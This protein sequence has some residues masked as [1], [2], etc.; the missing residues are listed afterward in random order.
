M[1]ELTFVS[2]NESKW[3]TFE[4]FTKGNLRL[5]PD[6]LAAYYVDIMDDL[7]YAK[8]FYPKSEIVKYLN[9]LTSKAHQRVYITKKEDRNRFSTFFTEEI[10]LAIRQCHKELL[11]ALIIFLISIG[12]G[13]VCSFMNPDYPR[14][15]LGDAYVDM[16]LDNIAKGDPMAVYKSSSQ[17]DMFFGIGSNNIKV[18]MVSFVL[19]LI[20]AIFAG[21]ILFSNGIMVGAFQTFFIQ[22][23]LFWTSF[24]TIFIHGALEL[25]AI[26]IIA[27]AGIV[28]GNSWWFPGTYSRIDSFILAAKKSMKIVLAIL[29][30][31][32]IAALIES[33]VTRHYQSM[34]EWGGMAIIIPSFAYII[35]YFIIYPIQVEKKLLKR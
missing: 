9:Q 10:P 27:G 23:G 3:K 2:K 25:S 29:P 11:I 31:I 16:T 13:S 6:E 12:I 4:S 26:V 15:I 21:F 5:T 18:G 7:S 1:K 22:Q 30:I 32:I 35:W 33:Y 14:V 34:G 20:G 17:D 28:I 19:G 24:T 8:T